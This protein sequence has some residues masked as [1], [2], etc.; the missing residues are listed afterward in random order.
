MRALRYLGETE[1]PRG[2]PVAL[3]TDAPEPSPVPGEAVLRPH[4]VGVSAI[5]AHVAAGDLAEERAAP[6]TLGSEFVGLVEH[7]ERPDARLRELVGRRVVGST[8]V[9]CGACDMCRAGLRAHC[10]RRAILGLLGRDGCFADAFALPAANLHALPDEIDDDAAVFVQPLAAAIQAAQQIHVEG[11]PYITV[12]GDGRL[13]LLCA[14]VMNRLNASVRVV[15]RHEDKLALCERWGVKHRHVDDVGRRADQDIV[16]D[17]TGSAS[18]LRTALRL[19]RPRGVVVLKSLYRPRADDAVDLS[20]VVR[21]EI[22]LVGSAGGPIAEA[23]R[24]L[25]ADEIDVVSLISARATLDDGLAALR[26][27]GDPATLEI[28]MDV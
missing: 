14:Q 5:D 22:E 7:A 19:V 6:I 15:G 13:G 8:I 25:A 9:V 20:P 23:I 10:R 3:V 24:M 26:R 11:K 17:C 18:G 2:T 12:L 16:V 1:A 27:A 21:N 4:R 28:L